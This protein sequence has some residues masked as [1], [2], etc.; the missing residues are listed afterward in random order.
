[1]SEVENEVAALRTKVA[2]LEAQLAARDAEIAQLKGEVKVEA[3]PEVE[4]EPEV[5][6]EYKEKVKKW[7][8]SE[9][10]EEEY[11][12]FAEI[13]GHIEEVMVHIEVTEMQWPA[14]NDVFIYLLGRD[15]AEELFYHV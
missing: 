6:D 13:K 4:S 1:M 8:Q 5:K 9:F 11:D 14:T 2:E 15:E 12:A 3:K 10:N 7:M